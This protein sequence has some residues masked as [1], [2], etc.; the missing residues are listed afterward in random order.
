MYGSVCFPCLTVHKDL[1]CI[2]ICRSLTV[3]NLFNSFGMLHANKLIDM[4]V[5]KVALS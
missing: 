2:F 5:N 3:T 4:T 1:H